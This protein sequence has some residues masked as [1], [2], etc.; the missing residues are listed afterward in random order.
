MSNLTAIDLFCGIG[1]FG[2]GLES[3][4]FN[5]TDAVD[6]DPV[7]AAA[8]KY[9]FPD[10]NVICR[11]IKTLTKADFINTKP[12][13][14]VSGTP[15][16]GFS[17]SG[18]RDANDFRNSLIFE[19]VRL[20]NEL[21]PRYFILENVPNILSKKNIHYVDKA[22]NLLSCVGYSFLPYQILNAVDYNVAQLRKRFFLI[23]Y[24]EGETV[25]SYPAPSILNFY[26]V[27]DVLSD[28]AEIEPFSK[29]DT[30]LDIEHLNKYKGLTNVPDLFAY[31]SGKKS[32][33]GHIKT[34]H[35]ADV[36][37]RFEKVLPGQ[38]DKISH[39]HRLHSNKFCNTLRAGTINT[40]HT[41]ARPIHYQHSRTITVREAA[42]LH[43]YPD[44]FEFPKAIYHA[45]R[46]IGN[47]VCPPVAAALG[48]SLLTALKKERSPVVYKALNQDRNLLHL[49]KA[50]VLKYFAG[51]AL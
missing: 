13:V 23:G 2:L 17:I 18:K 51:E 40:R 47:S 25:P 49:T 33:Y 8:H 50:Q 21:K 31:R 7:I 14:I 46:A 38:I 1:G 16:Q 12:D 24:R 30:G 43:G 22:V 48:E 34:N 9:N 26:K 45:F 4:S 19:T 41:A 37:A 29:V 6:N 35:T 3:C 11:D 20:V 5:I 44:S 15:C 10:C 39:F 32:V 28:L 27:N 42:R 36:V